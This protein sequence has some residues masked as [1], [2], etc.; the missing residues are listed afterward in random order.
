MR[1]IAV[2]NQFIPQYRVPAWEGLRTALARHGVRMRLIH[3]R[4]HRS[5]ASRGDTL[6][7][8]WSEEVPMRELRV[9]GKDLVYL[10]LG[11]LM[12][13]TDLVITNQE[14]R[15]LHNFRLLGEQLRGHGRLALM[16]HG[17]DS[18]K[19]S[20]FSA[21]EHLKIWMSRRVHWWFAYNDYT[22]REVRG[23]GFPA[24]RI[25]TF[26]NSTDTRS[27]RAA[28][29]ATTP[30]ELEALRQTLGLGDGPRAIYV[31]AIDPIKQIRFL[32][33]GARRARERIAGLELMIVGSGAERNALRAETSGEP[34]IHWIE[35][36][37]GAAKVRHMLLADLCLLPAGVGLG[38][39]DTFAL[40][41]P[42]VTTD[43]FPH[44]VEI[45]YLEH[46]VNGWMCRGT[47][48][49]AAFGDAVV[50][51]LNDRCVLARLRLGAL[52]SG[53]RLTVENMVKRFT[54]G[55]LAAIDAPDR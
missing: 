13:T 20:R 34:W 12:R 44:G 26:M 47:P 29:D 1:T 48:D 23:F 19:R 42:I 52:A 25:T 8:S 4:P 32:L 36:Q 24:D 46:G 14:V 54:D 43:R 9:A 11:D 37:F 55:I 15:L 35:P 51:L 31:G 40:G 7:L 50:H 16:G 33:A 10:Q 6:H 27:L 45:D 41:I 38:I 5:F 30:P 17:R 53:S 49:A 2:V 3:G 22:A 21:T 39:V 18:F 28:R